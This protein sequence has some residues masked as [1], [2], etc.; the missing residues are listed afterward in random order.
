MLQHQNLNTMK[1][2]ITLFIS[3][4]LLSTI[5]FAQQSR[6]EQ[7][8]KEAAAYKAAHPQTNANAQKITNIQS[9]SY[10][11]TAI[12]YAPYTY[13]GTAW[14]V[15]VDDIWSPVVNIGFVFTFFGDTFSKCLLGA[16]GQISFGNLADAG[17][18]EDWQCTT[19]L[20]SP[21][22]ILGNTI[23]C[24]YRD[25]DPALGGNC[26]YQLLGTAPN[27]Y[28]VVSWYNVPLFDNTG[29]QPNSTFQCVLYECTNYIDVIVGNSYSYASWNSGNGIIGIQDSAATVAYCPPGRNL[30]AWTATNEAW[31]FI[32]NSA[33]GSTTS[34]K[35]SGQQQA[36]V[37]IYPNPATNFI[38]I[39]LAANS[40]NTSIEIYNMIGECVKRQMATSSNCQINVADLSNGVYMLNVKDNAGNTITKKLLISN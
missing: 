39:S 11:V 8:F 36:T 34:I 20:P 40:E 22:D 37:K 2:H 38:Q 14:S 24:P 23:S 4:C 21:V 19:P 12:T 15:G 17:G 25:I 31:R 18:Y 5:V 26:Y 27:R 28:F 1:T 10:S 32:P 30:G 33:C 16:N 29:A 35:A 6:I 9:A 3:L 13:T 7:K